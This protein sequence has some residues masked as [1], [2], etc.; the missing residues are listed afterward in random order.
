MTA[1]SEFLDELNSLLKKYD[2]RLFAAVPIK[3]GQS[4]KD[5][6]LELPQSLE[7]PIRVIPNG[8]HD[9]KSDNAD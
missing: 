5:A 8:N 7:I 2:V 9:P 4:L 3:A 6:I 1:E